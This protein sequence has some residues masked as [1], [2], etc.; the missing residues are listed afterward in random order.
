MSQIHEWTGFFFFLTF[1]NMHLK[2]QNPT[3][4]TI[5]LQAL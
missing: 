4:L 3:A 5:N 1:I 2:V